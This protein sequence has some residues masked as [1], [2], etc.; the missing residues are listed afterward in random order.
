MYLAV[1]GYDILN[2]LKWLRKSSVT[3]N[4]M[5]TGSMKQQKTL[6]Q[7]SGQVFFRNEGNFEN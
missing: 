7:R 2:R 4:C 3:Q 1:I 6:C 5:C